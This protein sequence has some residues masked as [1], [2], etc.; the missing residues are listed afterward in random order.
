MPEAPEVR[1]NV[2]LLREYLLNRTIKEWDIKYDKFHCLE[3]E[4]PF[5]TKV[6]DIKSKGKT[7]YFEFDNEKFAIN[8]L[9]LHGGWVVNLEP[10]KYRFSIT[11]VDGD[12]LY[13]ISRDGLSKFEIVS[14]DELKKRLSKLGPD[15]METAIGDETISED[16]F[17]NLAK[18]HYKMLIGSFLMNQKYISGIGAYLR[19]DILNHAG[20]NPFRKIGTLENSELKKIYNSIIF[21]LK[22]VYEQGGTSKYNKELGL[23]ETGYDFRIY[24][25]EFDPDG[26]EVIKEGIG[27]RYVYWAPD[28]QE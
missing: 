28:S 26:N 10:E 22:N 13:F 25:K 1:I 20:I 7:I 23:G 6:V 27:G 11:T 15:L 9:M 12:I 8:H 4:I 18:N 24:N 14:E 3:D 17:V 19:S 5:G 2:D 21:T 16:E